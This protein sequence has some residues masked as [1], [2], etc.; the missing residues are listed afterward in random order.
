MELND[1]TGTDAGITRRTVIAGLAV[2]ALVLSPAKALAI[3]IIDAESAHMRA[4]DGDVLLIDIRTPEEWRETGVP[5]S[6]LAIT[7]HNQHF[8]TLLEEA[9]EGDRARPIALICA[10]GNRSRFVAEELAKR[11]YTNL[12]DVSEGMVGSASGPGWIS[13]G[14]P[15]RTVESGG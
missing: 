9:I 11:G 4:N 12:L 14:L 15:L 6:A 1:M 13:R 10:R 8:L 5:A 3:K 7:M 2:M